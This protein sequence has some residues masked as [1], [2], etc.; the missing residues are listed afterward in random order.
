MSEE[1]KVPEK[2]GKVEDKKIIIDPEVLKAMVATPEGKRTAKDKHPSTENP[3]ANWALVQN[4]AKF[5]TRA[6][7][8]KKRE[9]EANKQQEGNPEKTISAR[10]TVPIK[11]LHGLEHPAAGAIHMK[12]SARPNDLTFEEKEELRAISKAWGGVRGS[13]ICQSGNRMDL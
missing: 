9:E 5:R 13:G 8:K 12:L 4:V 1:K 10:E 6:P 3:I 2:E 11:V 7:S